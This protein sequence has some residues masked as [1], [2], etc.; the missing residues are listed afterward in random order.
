[1]PTLAILIYMSRKIVVNL[2]LL[3][4]IVCPFNCMGGLKSLFPATDA[5]I[6]K[7]ACCAP[8]A[9]GKSDSTADCDDQETTDNQPGSDQP[10][11][12]CPNCICHGAIVGSNVNLSDIDSI[13]TGWPDRNAFDFVLPL[14]KSSMA[15]LQIGRRNK[16]FVQSGIFVRISHRSLLI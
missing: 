10:G 11:D 16:S 4:I 13:D 9:N 12:R 5:L 2:L 3:A 14:S 7:C 1:M 8:T 15:A 6:P